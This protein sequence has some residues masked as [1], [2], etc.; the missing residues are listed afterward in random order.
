MGN[1]FLG[2]ET[3]SK[4]FYL[5]IYFYIC[6]FFHDYGNCY[7]SRSGKV[8]VTCSLYI[9]QPITARLNANA[10]LR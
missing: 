1:Y 9:D 3:N 6:I 2:R 10:W 8:G 4:E 7:K 5:F